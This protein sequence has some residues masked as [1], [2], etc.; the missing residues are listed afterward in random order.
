MAISSKNNSLII[1]TEPGEYFEIGEP[2]L[3][4]PLDTIDPMYREKDY[5]VVVAV[6][7]KSGLNECGECCI[8]PYCGRMD[9]CMK[10]ECF[11]PECS[12]F[13]RDDETEVIFKEYGNI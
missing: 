10:G 1:L 13:R 8:Q 4:K 11:I 5:K 6:S 2:F 7:N 3:Y 9:N 12:D